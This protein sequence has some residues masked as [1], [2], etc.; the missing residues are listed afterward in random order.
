M[1]ILVRLDVFRIMLIFRGLEYHWIILVAK[2]HFSFDWTVGW[3]SSVNVL[4]IALMGLY[5]GECVLGNVEV[6]LGA[7]VYWL[8]C[9]TQI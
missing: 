9:V 8:A 1:E 2:P 3:S 4:I 5:L 6:R 7:N